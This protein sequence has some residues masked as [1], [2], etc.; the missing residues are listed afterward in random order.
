VFRSAAVVGQALPP[1]LFFDAPES[2]V[3]M[4]ADWNQA[5]LLAR[6]CELMLGGGL[7]ESN[8]GKAIA[9]VR[10]FG[11]DVSSG[12]ESAPGIKD[13]ALVRAFISAA[14]KAAKETGA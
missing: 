14:R 12:V 10:P 8:V 2:G 4:R 13:A 6:Q 9:T 11:V 5:A 7:D 3:G 1:R